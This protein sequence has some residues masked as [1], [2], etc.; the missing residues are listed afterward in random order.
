MHKKILDTLVE[1]NEFPIIF[2]GSGIS[3]RYLKDYPS[4]VE[5]LEILWNE[6]NSEGNFYGYL[7]KVRDSLSQD[8]S[9]PDYILDYEV[10]VRVA[11][12]LEKRINNLFAEEKIKIDGINHKQVYEN[13]ISPF[14]ALIC[15]KF[16]KYELI[17]EMREEY[18]LF[19]E[20]I[21]KSQIILT[22]NYDSFIEDSY[23]KISNI[24]IKKYI[25]QRGFFEQTTGFSEVYKIHGCSSENKSIVITENDYSKFD[26]DSVLISAKIISML[27]NSPII[28][29]G[30]SLK[31]RNIRNIIKDFTNSLTSDELLK[32]ERRLIV[33]EWS[34]DEEKII[35]DIENDSELG[36]RFT[37]IRTDNYS[38]IYNKIKKINQGVSPAEIRRYQHV[39]KRLI[40][41]KGKEGSLETVLLSPCQLDE[42][43]DIDA[44]KK[45]VV[46]IGDST[47]VFVMPTLIT[48]IYDYICEKEHQN[49]ENI[50]RFLATQQGRVP[51]KKYVTE[52]N[53]NNDN[54]SE[55]EKE[56]LR[57]I[58]KKYSDIESQKRSI[59]NYCSN[60]HSIEE[61][62]KMNLKEYVEYNTIAM[63][64]DNI[65]IDEVKK[66]IIDKLEILKKNKQTIR[67]ELRKLILIYDLKRN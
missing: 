32:L 30:Y 1:S 38:K 34:K 64:I 16:K 45:L 46:A 40:V 22:T 42:N 62:K 28:F 39:I 37:I 41:S 63:N 19:K 53:I 36:C 13:K 47:L 23:N 20:M 58:I 29:I 44:Q 17:D 11:T 54:L 35:E 65:D 10:N 57:K 24:Q 2:I 67:S 3:K 49:I 7:S 14:K 31:D 55:K 26:K 56:K 60:I 59:K 25:G 33:V 12:E 5:L 8:S 4:W 61:I 43:E 50:L 48:Y 51:F 21:S 27:L 9:L 18:E 6:S 52:E 66:Y 15:N